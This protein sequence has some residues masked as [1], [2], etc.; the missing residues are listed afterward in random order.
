MKSDCSYDVR[1]YFNQNIY[2]ID[3][4]HVSQKLTSVVGRRVKY[5]SDK[6]QV[7]TKCLN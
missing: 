3:D 5:R 4:L 7:I 6:V 2:N 1:D